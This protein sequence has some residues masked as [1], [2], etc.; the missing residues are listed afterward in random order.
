[1]KSG[2]R[3]WSD[4]TPV[5]G[6]QFEYG[7][8]DIGNRTST[9]AGGDS[10]GANLRSASYTNNTLN[11]ITGRDVAGYV[12]IIGAATATATNVNVNNS[13]AYRR[14]EYFWKELSV[15][16]TSAAKWQSVTNRAVQSGTTNLVTGDVFLAK[17][18]EVFGYDVDGNETNDGRWMFTWDAEN[19]LT[20]VESLSTGPTA[21]KRMVEFGYDWQGRMV[22][23]TEYNGS[24]GSYVITNDLKFLHDGWHYLAE[25]NATNN[26]L[27]RSYLWGSDLSGSMTGAGGVGGL[28]AMNSAANGIHFT[29]YDGN[30]NV[31][32]LV[33][34]TDGSASANYEYDPFGQSI[35]CTGALAK[36]NP[37]RFSTKRADDATDLVHYEYRTYSASSGKWLNRDPIEEDGGANLYQ[38]FDNAPPSKIDP[39]GQNPAMCITGSIAIGIGGVGAALAALPVGAIVTGIVVVAGISYVTYELCK[40][41]FKKRC[42]P[43]SPGVGT[44]MYRV[45]YPPG[46]GVPG[47]RPHWI[48]GVREPLHTHHT[49]VTQ[50]S[51]N[52][53]V[54]PCQ[55]D[56]RELWVSVGITPGLLEI[57]EV[58]PTGGGVTWL[59]F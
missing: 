24:S 59:P 23:R 57:P 55:C 42:K 27:V 34:G 48:D 25:L 7:F 31:T 29:C 58:E 49:V 40:R 41:C 33:K 54:G 10:A 45:D 9:K 2:K 30:G 1:M 20:K 17:T 4:W 6:Q 21:S 52:A 35:R 53:L 19:R 51:V 39:L 14:G 26:A 50:R 43:C 47:S 5:A 28:L 44:I 8:D 12:S 38:A 32:A 16:N 11:Q 18:A 46:P 13:L 36:E 22:R 37:Y 56:I 15:G 3:Y